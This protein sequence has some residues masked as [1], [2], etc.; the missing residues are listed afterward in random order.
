MAWP[1]GVQGQVRHD[2][3]IVK[4]SQI[5]TARQSVGR[6]YQGTPLYNATGKAIQN[7]PAE[8][9][10]MF[11]T[12]TLLTLPQ[13]R[14]YFETI[15]SI[16]YIE[17]DFIGH[18]AGIST[19]PYFPNDTYFERQWSFHNEGNNVSGVRAVADADV[20]MP[21][22]WEFTQGDEDLIIAILDTGIKTD[23][24]EFAGR[25]WVN[26]LEIADNDID[27]DHNGAVDD[28]HGWNFV[29]DNTNISDPAGHGTHMAG[30][31]GATGNNGIGYAGANWHSRLMICK[32]VDRDFKGRYSWWTKGIYYAV[33]HGA[34]IINMSLGG[35]DASRTLEEAI[36]YAHQHNVLVV[37]SMQNQNTGETYYPAGIAEVLAVG[38]TDPDDKRSTRFSGITGYGSNYGNHI[39]LVAPG[40]YIYG[41][42]YADNNNYSAL[43]S[44]TSPAAALVS[45][46]ASLVWSA[47]ST[48][49]VQ[50]VESR[51]L[52]AAEDE[53]GDPV[54]DTPG[55]DPYYGYGRVNAYDALAG[56]THRAVETSFTLYPNPTREQVYITIPYSA[57]E[58]AIRLYNHVGQQLQTLTFATNRENT[59]SF[60][61]A[62]LARGLYYVNVQTNTGFIATQ[63]LVLEP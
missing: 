35:V 53:V 20:D 29:G 6:H 18:T 26:P 61:I 1:S 59:I 17:P 48:L 52:N 31:I 12:D 39:D 2:Q 41:L 33:D 27:D 51:L 24:P 45:G 11:K 62:P 42:S 55:W 19:A 37:A 10:W 49:T 7:H 30:V 36:Q 22:A 50:Q 40:N 13:A 46:I 28:V 4:Y 21:E 34:R 54:E 43:H 63:K 16:E 8:K 15:A 58:V 23:H 56:N 57:T 9:L 5:P 25:L 44:G 3:W 38:S 47:D 32:V 14:Q 60:S